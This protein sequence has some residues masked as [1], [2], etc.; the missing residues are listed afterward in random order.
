MHCPV[1]PNKDTKVVDTRLTSDGL[2]IRRRRE[3]ERCGYRFSTVE[4]V[5]LLDM[6]VVKRDG[7]REPYSREKIMRGLERALEKRPFT[8]TDFQKLVHRIE[9]DIQKKRA[10]EI[11]S[12]DLGEIVMRALQKFDTVAYIRFASVYRSFADVAAFESE[13]KTIARAKHR[14]SKPKT[15]RPLSSLTQN[16]KRQTLN[17]L[18]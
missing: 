7:R 11:T 17:P 14:S 10:G 9:R 6:V 13:L 5:T 1:C 12:L 15:D 18:P 3:C 2:S 8:E 4:E 16:P